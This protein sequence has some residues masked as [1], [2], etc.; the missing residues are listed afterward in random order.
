AVPVGTGTNPIARVGA[1][2]AIGGRDRA[3]DAGAAVAPGYRPA[4]IVPAERRNDVVAV[5]QG[6]DRAHPFIGIA[7]D[8]AIVLG[9]DAA[10]A[11]RTVPPGD[12]PAKAVPEE[13]FDQIVAI[14]QA[15]E[16]AVG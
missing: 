5:A 4:V 12:R 1:D 14:A 16:C 8:Q 10:A 3:P 7:A 2:E 11:G 9:D 13:A 6:R 15:D